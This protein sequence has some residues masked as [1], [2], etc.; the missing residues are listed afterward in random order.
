MRHHCGLLHGPYC[1]HH[2]TNPPSRWRPGEW[3]S[4]CHCWDDEQTLPTHGFPASHCIC[5]PCIAICFAFLSSS[6]G[7]GVVVEVAIETIKPNVANFDQLE[8]TFKHQEKVKLVIVCQLALLPYVA[9]IAH[10]RLGW[11]QYR[12]WGMACRS[13][14][15]ILSYQ[16]L[17]MISRVPHCF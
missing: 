6:G 17:G 13:I 3:L 9:W 10:H 15:D 7:G 1:R 16:V 4:T 2:Q 12:Y 5:E 8:T 14:L 11:W